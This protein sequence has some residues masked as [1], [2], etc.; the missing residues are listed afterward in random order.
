MSLKLITK[1]EF[2][3]KYIPE[4]TKAKEQTFQ[5]VQRDCIQMGYTDVFLKPYSNQTYIVEERY[6][7][8]LIAKAELEYGR[9]LRAAQ[10][11]A[12]I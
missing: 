3:K 6:Q 2:F 12:R 11:A 10:T 5:R 1:A 7:D 9:K 8:F 4:T